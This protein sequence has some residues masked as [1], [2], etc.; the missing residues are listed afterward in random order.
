MTFIGALS[1]S[2]S[3]SSS[4]TLPQSTNS[5]QG[6]ASGI[7]TQSMVDSMVEAAQAP[8]I[9]MLQQRQVLLWKSEQY[10]QVN[11]A[12]SN[13]QNSLSSMRLQSSY[14]AQQTSST[15]P[16]LVS[17][18]S[19]GLAPNGTYSVSVSQL[20]QAA[21]ISS[22]SSLSTDSGYGD[23]TLSQISSNLPSSPFN[24]TVNGES[25]SVNPNADTINTV[26]QKITSD[27]NTGVAGF[28]DS[29]SGKVVMQTTATGSGAQI[30][31]SADTTSDATELFQNIMG[32]QQPATTVTSASFTN[33]QLTTGGTLD[34]N[35]TK[36]TVTQGE[37][38]TDV[39]SAINGA[40]NGAGIAGVTAQDNGDGT[41]SLLT[42]D[43]YS[44]LSLSSDTSSILQM[45]AN[46][47]TGDMASQDAVYAVNGVSSSSSSNSPVFNGVTLNLQG[48]ISASSPV[49]I[50]VSTN[51]NQ[52]V[53][54]ITNFVQT[55]NQTLQTL[56]GLYNQ[57]RNYSYQPLTAA[58]ESQ[59]TQTQIDQ[60]NQKAQ[61]GLLGYD[62]DLGRALS[63]I[64]QTASTV[65]SGLTDNGSI[66]S[67]SD[68]GIT[69]ISVLNG[70]SA[71]ATA[72]GVTTT[73]VNTYGLLQIDTA[74]LTQAVQS[75]PT[76]VMNLFTNT[77]TDST[78]QGLAKQLYTAVSNAA[79]NISQDAGT[80]QVVLPTT[81]NA[82]T[83]Q[84]LLPSTG[85]DPNADFTSLFSSD[86][87][88]TS[89]IGE[90]ISA[91]DTQAE[92]LQKQIS[93]QQTMWQN[94][95]AQ[96][97]T[98]IQSLNSQQSELIGMLGS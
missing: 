76:A 19:T 7:D 32:L 67:L 60:W 72:P 36:I 54:N 59:M 77:S 69:P 81:P 73:G 52:I 29:N 46:V 47:P 57:Q 97:E 50:T 71:G 35:G 41:L 88:N 66:T 84:I 13:L 45:T 90:Q 3:S 70:V 23:E 65:L 40:N 85:I 34:I 16:S 38:L 87:Y 21:T 31:L 80:S 30:Q 96:M 26:L 58:Q 2:T 55:Y 10:Q 4:Y 39:A 68:I 15:N 24:I 11:T 62:P 89:L 37:S 51:T 94:Q 75:N 18:T 42:T 14:L 28:Y 49:T 93:S 6:L 12:L 20:A 86:S 98:A 74:Q 95:F 27:T 79:Q 92:A 8:L 63:S 61:A 17:A 33:S 5:I 83:G 64:Q 43:L 56:Q 82:N 91:I 53:Q 1:G 44:P 25:I 9:S 78:Q 48:T 22:Q